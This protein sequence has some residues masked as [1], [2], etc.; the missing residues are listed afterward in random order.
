M[1]VHRIYL[2]TI[3]HV[4]D[5]A[6]IE[7]DEAKHAVRVKRVETGDHVQ[8]LDGA[9]VIAKGVVEDRHRVSR[10]PGSVAEGWVLPIRVRDVHRADR[11][12]PAVHVRSA[13]PKGA[14]LEEMIDSLSQAGAASWAPLETERGVVDPR[15]TK[16]ARI[17]RV[18]VEASKQCGRPWIMS[19]DPRETLAHAQA[20]DGGVVVLA[21]AGGEPY[22]ATG[23][24]AIRLLIGPEGGWSK[25]ELEGIREGKQVK[26]CSFGPHAMRI[27]TAAAIAAGTILAVEGAVRS[28]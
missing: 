1:S 16:L 10:A 26:I 11:V 2:E 28:K 22:R 12:C 7:G 14:R 6:W 25:R 9:G 3:P 23:A 18:A 17:E 4:G 5:I 15:E 19:I 8:L 13:T 20:W 27:E 21:D 24:A